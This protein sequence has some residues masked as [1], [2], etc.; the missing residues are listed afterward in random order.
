MSKCVR[1]QRKKKKKGKLGELPRIGR[2][3]GGSKH[4]RGTREG[5]GTE[6][7]GPYSDAWNMYR[8]KEF[9]KERRE[10]RNR[11]KTSMVRVTKTK[12]RTEKRERYKARHKMSHAVLVFVF[13]TKF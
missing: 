12:E 1:S 13:F 5:R 3:L 8:K 10:E 6:T 2:E 7:I 11:R 9:R 4:I